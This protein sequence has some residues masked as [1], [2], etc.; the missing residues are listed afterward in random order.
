MEEIKTD[1]L[2]PEQFNSEGLYSNCL[3]FAI[4]V[5]KKIV[6]DH[7]EELYDKGLGITY[8][9]EKDIGKSFTE[10][11]AEYGMTIKEVKQI[12]DLKG[13]TGFIIYGF[14]KRKDWLGSYFKDEFHVVRINS[15]GTAVEKPNDS[16][17]SA[18][19]IQILD[20]KGRTEAFNRPDTPIR[21]FELVEEKNKDVE[22]IEQRKRKVLESVEKYVQDK[23]ELSAC[24]ND[25][26]E[27]LNLLDSLDS[28]SCNIALQQAISL[29]K[30]HNIELDFDGR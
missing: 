10:R 27:I 1:M 6:L 29:A 15:D 17:S 22:K 11:L 9:D 25:I 14:F 7:R 24:A 26:R 19:I 4:G 18:E 20:D 28:S 12:S 16:H 13:K 21:I 30:E 3:G 2:T 5:P 23:P 8:Y